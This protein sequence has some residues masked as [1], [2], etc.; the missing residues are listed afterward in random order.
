MVQPMPMPKG[1]KPQRPRGERRTKSVRINLTPSEKNFVFT[2][3]V[4]AGQS[5]AAWLY[6]QL[7]PLLAAAHPSPAPDQDALPFPTEETR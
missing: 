7:A 3:A 1:A 6:D 5:E 2:S 4:A